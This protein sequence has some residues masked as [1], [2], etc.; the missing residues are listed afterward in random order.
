MFSEFFKSPL[1]RNAIEREVKAVD[2]EHSNNIRNEA[3]RMDV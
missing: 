2:S 1:I 3:W